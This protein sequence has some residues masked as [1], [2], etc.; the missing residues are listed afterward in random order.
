LFEGY[1]EQARRVLFFARHEAAQ[2][3]HTSVESEELLLGLIRE[4]AGVAA[5]ILAQLH[6]S[7][8]DLHQEINGAGSRRVPASPPDENGLGTEAKRILRFAAEEAD[9]FYMTVSIPNICSLG[10][11]ATRDQSRPRSSWRAASASPR[12][13][14]AS[15]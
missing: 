12:S 10:S 3:A 4:S 13:G 14:T 7:L 9:R 11:F 6:M 2:V 1:T 15:S 8:E 5:Q